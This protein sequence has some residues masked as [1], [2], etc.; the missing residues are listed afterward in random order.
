MK[1]KTLINFMIVLTLGLI[2]NLFLFIYDQDRKIITTTDFL[3]VNLCSILLI[4]YSANKLEK[5]DKKEE[6][7]VK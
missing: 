3:L 6:T 4:N 5:M 7:V 2:V 1:R